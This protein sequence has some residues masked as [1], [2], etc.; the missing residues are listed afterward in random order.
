[1]RLKLIRA[2]FLK[3][4]DVLDGAREDPRGCRGPYEPWRALAVSV[5]ELLDRDDQFGTW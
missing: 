5:D 3:S 4:V 1:M 2:A